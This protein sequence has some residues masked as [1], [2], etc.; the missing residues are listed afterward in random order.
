MAPNVTYLMQAEAAC[1][2]D[3][4]ANVIAHVAGAD[5]RLERVHGDKKDVGEKD[6][7]KR[8]ERGKLAVTSFVLLKSRSSLERSDIYV[9]VHCC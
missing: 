9:L 1:K 6:G 5:A 3:G 8:R 2:D 4:F 7:R